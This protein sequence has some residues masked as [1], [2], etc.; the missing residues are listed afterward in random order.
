VSSAVMM[1]A[2]PVCCLPVLLLGS[3]SLEPVT[4]VATASPTPAAAEQAQ[5]WTSP[6]TRREDVVDDYSGTQVADPYRWLEDQNSAEVAAWMKTQN[7]A[8]RA[9]LD[10]VPER[11]A[12]RARLE[13]LWNFARYD[14]PERAGKRWFWRR[15]DGLQ[16]QAVLW[17]ADAPDAEGHP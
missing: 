14:A 8:T 15:N 13:E 9:V 10:A 1:R 6:P 7:A 12:I 2:T 17:V 4:P 3:C 11:A 16:N 5:R